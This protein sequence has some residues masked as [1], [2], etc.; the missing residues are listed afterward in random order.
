MVNLRIEEM[1]GRAFERQ[2][3]RQLCQKGIQ[4][5]SLMS[6]RAALKWPLN[7]LLSSRQVDAQKTAF[8][9]SSQT[10]THTH[11]HT[12]TPNAAVDQ[13]VLERSH[14]EV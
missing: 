8:P 9:S 5:H 3:E 14:F 6:R 2:G 12:R 7:K 10:D 11:T 13:R 4:G 1:R